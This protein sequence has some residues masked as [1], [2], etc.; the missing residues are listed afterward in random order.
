[1]VEFFKTVGMGASIVPLAIS[2]VVVAAGL[3]ALWAP[4]PKRQNRAVQVLKI[5][6]RIRSTSRA[7][8]TPTRAADASQPQALPRGGTDSERPGSRGEP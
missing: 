1:M 2:I 4:S 3:T 7:Q 5:V 6:L 8:S